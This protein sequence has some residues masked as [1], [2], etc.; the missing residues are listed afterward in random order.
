MCLVVTVHQSDLQ[1]F[2]PHQATLEAIR[3]IL[4]TLTMI[5]IEDM[6]Q[7]SG[8]LVKGG[9]LINSS[10]IYNRMGA[11]LSSWMTGMVN[12]NGPPTLQIDINDELTSH[13]NLF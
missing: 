10:Y 6:D 11:N 5:M 3:M 13:N 1:L 8:S 2:A 7:E 4:M 9:E 12:E